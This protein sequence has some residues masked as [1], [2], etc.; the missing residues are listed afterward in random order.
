MGLITLSQSICL[1]LL[2]IDVKVFHRRPNDLRNNWTFNSIML[3]ICLHTLICVLFLYFNDSVSFEGH[4]NE[5]FLVCDLLAKQLI[6]KI[7]A[8]WMD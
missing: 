7:K 2:I 5:I 8:K 6:L 3:I 1:K 4:I